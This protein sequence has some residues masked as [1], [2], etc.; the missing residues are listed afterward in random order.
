MAETFFSFEIY[1][2]DFYTNFLDIKANILNE[3]QII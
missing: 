3:N 2:F 1:Q